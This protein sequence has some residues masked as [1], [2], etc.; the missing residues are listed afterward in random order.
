MSLT[1]EECG[2]WFYIL[3]F[4]LVGRSFKKTIRGGFLRKLLVGYDLQP[5]P[6][7]KKTAEAFLPSITRLKIE[8]NGRVD[9]EGWCINPI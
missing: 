9:T 5:P 2:G 3:T 1:P 4:T 8:L 7:K 6:P